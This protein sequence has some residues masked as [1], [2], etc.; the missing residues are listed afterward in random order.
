MTM[1]RSPRLTALAGSTVAVGLLAAACTNPTVAKVPASQAPATAKAAPAATTAAPKLT[2]PPSGPVGTTFT[3]TGPNGPN[4]GQSAYSVTLVRVD[5]PATPDNSY[6]G[7]D[8]GKHLVGAE[9]TIKGVTSSS[10]DDANVDATLLGADAQTYQSAFN[11]LAA[12]TNF[13]SGDFSVAPGGTNTGWVSFAVPD[14][15]TVR[16]VQWQ[17]GLDGP[18]GTWTVSK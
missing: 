18:T 10:R 14:G 8:A 1:F 3:V 7:A 2:G 5:D 4:D 13:N 16:A 11:G 12:G 6:D 15:V 9:F 17:T